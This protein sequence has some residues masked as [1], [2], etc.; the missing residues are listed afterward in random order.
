MIRPIRLEEYPRLVELWES[1]VLATHDFLKE[2]DFLYYKANLPT[3]FGFVRLWGLELEGK[4]VGFMG[5]ADQALEMLFIDASIRGKGIGKQL[6]AFGIQ[7]Q[8]VTTVEVNE[9]ND[10]AVGFYQ[11]MGFKIKS[12][13]ALDGQGK[14]YPILKMEL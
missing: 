11:H 10:Q 5:I 9:Q 7:E 12:R 13:S 2:E 1:A 3:Y 4:L 14:E 8:G 6:I